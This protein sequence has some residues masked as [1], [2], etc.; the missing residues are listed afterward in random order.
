MR[1]LAGR[2]RPGCQ[3]RRRG[4]RRRRVV[5]GLFPARGAGPVGGHR[6][7]GTGRRR[8]R[9]RAQRRPRR[10]A[11]R[12]R[13]DGDLEPQRVLDERDGGHGAPRRRRRRPR[14]LRRRHVPL[15]LE[16]ARAAPR[17][18]GRRALRVRARARAA[19]AQTDRR[20]PLARL[21]PPAGRRRLRHA[22][23][24]VPRARPLRA[25]AGHGLRPLQ[26]AG[27]PGGIRQRVRRRREPGQLQPGRRH[28][29]LRG[30]GE[31]RGRGAASDDRLE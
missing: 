2:G 9:P 24:A 1:R 25:H 16:R 7:L 15:P 14:R 19:G 4:Q 5:G 17:G 30:H 11:V 10:Q 20:Q 31:P 26:V 23:I 3:D 27:R 18:A 12:R 21:R 22:G 6:R 13:R 8:R 29:R 28:E